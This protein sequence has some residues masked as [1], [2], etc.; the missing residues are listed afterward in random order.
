MKTAHIIAGTCWRNPIPLPHPYESIR[1]A[2]ARGRL[3]SGECDQPLELWSKRWV[4]TGGCSARGLTPRRSRQLIYRV[5]SI[6]D[7]NDYGIKPITPEQ[8][9]ARER[10][11]PLH[12]GLWKGLILQTSRGEQVVVTDEWRW[13]ACR[14]GEQTDLFGAVR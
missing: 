8:R 6:D 14:P 10:Y 4:I 13:I 2:D 9:L 12:Y 11:K 3:N 1:R 5:I 7:A